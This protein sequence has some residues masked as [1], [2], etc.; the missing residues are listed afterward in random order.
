LSESEGGTL[1]SHHDSQ[2]DPVRR[3]EESLR[4]WITDD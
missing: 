1:R 2:H 4:G 3:V